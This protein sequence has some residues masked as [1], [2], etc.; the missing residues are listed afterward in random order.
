MS[1][2][3]DVGGA[4]ANFLAEMQKSQPTPDMPAHCVI[5]I[6]NCEL[7]AAL[8]R[9]MLEEANRGSDLADIV[10]ATANILAEFLINMSVPF[11]M[12]IKT[13]I[14]KT[15]EQRLNK[16]LRPIFLSHEELVATR[17]SAGIPSTE[18]G[19]A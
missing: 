4:I 16:S 7:R 14:C 17:P 18:G 11:D 10:E 1:R 6:R 8:M 9:F 15:F 3:Y 2:H 5:Q 12:E 19:H 13:L